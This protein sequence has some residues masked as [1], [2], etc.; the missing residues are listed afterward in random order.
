MISIFLKHPAHLKE[1]EKIS[2]SPVYL[3]WYLFFWNTQKISYKKKK[4]WITLYI[5]TDIYFSETPC[6]SHIKRKNFWIALYIWTDIY[7]SE[8]PC[9]SHIKRKNFWIALYIWTD[10]Y[11]SE[12]PCTSQI[13]R[14]KF[15]NQPVYLNWYL[16]FWNTVYIS[17]DITFLETLST[18]EM[19]SLFLKHS[20]HLIA[21]SLTL[22]KSV[23]KMC[24]YLQKMAC[25]PVWGYFISKG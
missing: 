16:F 21:F 19:I 8:T 18:S 11:F 23:H 6:R 5:W 7:F 22:V 13:K 12:T 1:K 4:F 20:L 9:R 14:K 17:N 3:N 15:L 10:I 25:Q 2:E 24:L